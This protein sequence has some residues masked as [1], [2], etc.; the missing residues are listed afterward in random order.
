MYE[1]IVEVIKIYQQEDNSVN[2]KKS[3]TNIGSKND[4]AT[5]PV[6]AGKSNKEKPSKEKPSKSKKPNK[7]DKPKK[8]KQPDT[9]KREST[10]REDVSAAPAKSKSKGKDKEDKSKKEKEKEKIP[11]SK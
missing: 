7:P 5:V 8:E 1:K 6:K 2:I 9:S 11:A 4:A 10:P 3:L